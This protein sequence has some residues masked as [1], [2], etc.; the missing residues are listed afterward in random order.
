MQLSCF[1]T[2]QVDDTVILTVL[3]TS[4]N[5][6]N[7]HWLKDE[8]IDYLK[9]HQPLH[10]VILN[11]NN[12]THLGHIGLGALIAINNQLRTQKMHAFIGVKPEVESIFKSSHVDKL[13]HVWHP[14]EAC[15][16][17]K[18]MDCVHKQELARKQ[19]EFLAQDHPIDDHQIP[20]L[21]TKIEH[22]EPP[23]AISISQ[24]PAYRMLEAERARLENRRRFFWGI[25]I[26]AM[27]VF[28]VIVTGL[29]AWNSALFYTPPREHILTNDE[30][31]ERFDKNQD[32]RFDRDDLP[33]LSPVDKM[34][35]SNSPWCRKLKIECGAGF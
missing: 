14:Q 5:A 6:H 24:G 12:V 9:K 25:G 34:T 8:V 31:I 11:L 3:L 19:V 15:L 10:G 30:L 1:K 29:F 4:I 35:L 27:S 20:S 32:G 17:C 18:Q 23:S 16:L 22:H 28:L 2:S 21:H 7:A 13:F 26:G 33:L